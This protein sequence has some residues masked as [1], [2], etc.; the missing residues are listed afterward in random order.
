MV[1]DSPIKDYVQGDFVC[2]S[3]TDVIRNF[4]IGTYFCGRTLFSYKWTV[5]KWHQSVCRLVSQPAETSYFLFGMAEWE[6]TCENVCIIVQ[7]PGESSLP[8]WFSSSQ[9]EC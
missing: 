5:C 9:T 2:I 3:V 6:S 4:F 7:Y 8:E 1:W